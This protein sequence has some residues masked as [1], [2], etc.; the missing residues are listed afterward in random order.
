[1]YR[2][3][4]SVSLIVLIFLGLGEIYGQTLPAKRNPT[5]NAVVGGGGGDTP[6]PLPACH[7]MQAPVITGTST[8]TNG[9]TGSVNV[10]WTNVGASDYTVF[11]RPSGTTTYFSGCGGNPS[12]TISSVPSGVAY[13][14][15]V[16][17]SRDCQTP[18]NGPSVDT[19]TSAVSVANIIVAQPTILAPT[20]VTQSSFTANWSASNGATNYLIDVNTNISFTGTAIL[21]NVS[22]STSTSRTI[23]NLAANTTYYYRVRASNSFATSGSAQSSVP[24]LAIPIPLAPAGLAKT[25]VASTS[26]GLSWATT[27]WADFYRLDLAGTSDFSTDIINSNYQ[28]NSTS[29]TLNGLD[30]NKTYYTRVRAV[31]VSGVSANSQ[32]LSFVTCAPVPINLTSSSVTT[33]SFNLNWTASAGASSYA[34]DVAST[35]NFST[36]VVLSNSPVS[37]PAISVTG[38]APGT[39]YYARVRSVSA[40]GA[41]PN[42][43]NLIVT[44]LPPIPTGG[45]SLSPTTSSFIATW[46]PVNNADHYFVDV[47]TSSSFPTPLVKTNLDAGSTP[48]LNIT[49]LINATTYYFRVRASN[50][51]GTSA[52]SQPFS[53]TTVVMPAPATPTVVAGSLGADIFSLNWPSVT[54]AGNYSVDVSTSSAFDSGVTNMMSTTTTALLTGLQQG[55]TYYCRVRAIGAGGPSAPSPSLTVTTLLNSP[56]GLTATAITSTSFKATWSPIAGA[57]GYRIDVS[58]NNLFSS[59]NVVTDQATASAEYNVS[60]LAPGTTYYYRVKTVRGS[61]VSPYST[62]A[63]MLSAPPAATGLT[64]SSPTV[65]SFTARWQPVTGTVN[66]YLVDIADNAGFNPI[67]LLGVD[68]GTNT[69]KDITGLTNG[70]TYYFRV[71]ATNNGG[72]SVSASALVT[73]PAMGVPADLVTSSITS[74]SFRLFWSP[75]GATSYEANVSAESTFANPIVS[76]SAVDSIT[77]A[78]LSAARSYYCRVRANGS[79]GPSAWSESITIV[80]APVVT[81]A[82]VA[83]YTFVV[84]CTDAGAETGYYFEVSESPSFSPLL[85]PFTGTQPISSPTLNTFGLQPQHTYYVRARIAI[86]HVIS[87]Y[88]ETLSVTSD[89]DRDPEL[90]LNGGETQPFTFN[91]IPPSPEASALAKYADVPVSLYSGTPSISIPLYEVNERGLRLPIS[92]SYHGGGNKV[93]QAAPRTGL[94]WTL[95][96]GGVVTRVVRGW[97]D[98]HPRGFLS[99]TEQYNNVDELIGVSDND[100]TKSDIYHGMASDCKDGEPDL[101]YFNFGG[102]SGQFMYDWDGT[103]RIVSGNSIKIEALDRAD[104]DYFTGWKIT[105]DD[106]TSYVFSVAEISELQSAAFATSGCS[107]LHE[108]NDKHLPQSWYL[109]EMSSADGLCSIRFEY[110]SRDQ[111][112]ESDGQQTLVYD[113]LRFQGHPINAEHFT[114]K[115]TYHGKYL[116]RISTT[117]LQ[118]AVDFE[119]ATQPRTD[120]FGN[121]AQSVPSFPLGRIKVTSATGRS[122]VSWDLNYSN[123]THRLTLESV[124]ETTGAVA[125]PPYKFSYNSPTLPGTNSTSI[126]HWG[127]LNSNTEG[128]IPATAVHIPSMPNSQRFSL[129]GGDRSPDGSKVH[130][131]MLTEI[132]YP[133]GG[134]D[135]LTFESN[136]YSFE[137]GNELTVTD[138]VT[139]EVATTAPTE[140]GERQTSQ[141]FV[142]NDTRNLLLSY[143]FEFGDHRGF[144]GG[145]RNPGVLVVDLGTGREIFH[146]VFSIGE[147]PVNGESTVSG[148]GEEILYQIPPGNYKITATGYKIRFTDDQGTHDTQNSASVSISWKTPVGQP[149]TEIHSGGGVRIKQIVRSFGNGNPDKVTRYDY[150]MIE[151]GML[152]S[153]GSLLEL[154]QMYSLRMR[155]AVPPEAPIVDSLYHLE[156]RYLRFSRNHAPLGTTQGS[157]VGYEQVTVLDGMNGENGKSI[158]HFRSPRDVS[159]AISTDIPFPPARSLDFERGLLLDEA[160]FDAD[161]DTV[162]FVENEYQFTIGN[163]PA[164]KV[165][166][167]YPGESVPWGIGPL[168]ARYAVARYV[169]ALGYSRLTQTREK[170]F[171]PN[172]SSFETVTSYVYNET[173]HKQLVRSSRTNSKGETI[174]TSLKYPQDYGASSAPINKLQRAHI[175]NVPVETLTWKN[176]TG[177]DVQLLSASKTDF[178]IDRLNLIALPQTRSGAKITDPVVTSDPYTTA[179]T[180]Y[181]PRLVVGSY[182]DFNNPRESSR[183]DGKKTAYQ[184]GYNQTVL[185]AAAENALFTDMFYEGFEENPSASVAEQRTGKKSMQLSGVFSIMTDRLPAHNGDY[186]LSYWVKENSGP[187]TYKEKQFN[188]Y[189]TGPIATDAVNGFLDEVRL[190]PKG[191][192]MTTYTYEL[193]I[194]I[195]SITDPANVTTYFEY[196]DFNRLAVK[197]D[198][199]RNI[200]AKYDYGVNVDVPFQIPPPRLTSFAPASGQAG[201]TVV[202]SGFNFSPVPSENTVTFNGVA[203]TV[204]SST[205]AQLSVT[206]PAAATTGKVAITINGATI[207]SDGVFTVLTH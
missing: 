17:A 71:R 190:Y 106:G 177:S 45:S 140:S 69:Q 40:A 28:V 95:N 58:T 12:C 199:D 176:G 65:S 191:A 54:G 101:F 87:G 22:N 128:L 47:S 125:K 103:I 201:A 79:G 30:P 139:H 202:I 113:L 196:D 205:G 153:S 138:S 160:Q 129:P 146:R 133:T 195:T 120:V 151:G 32:T 134:K 186:V 154:V 105:V 37:G 180:L 86:N 110:E 39:T 187:W 33:T 82:S 11:Y 52:S 198:Q 46:Q 188:N 124:T 55:T 38:L 92:L 155:Y 34:V 44:L 162:R 204:N 109:S 10:A 25:A 108:F 73:L 49:G 51:A 89:Q 50:T 148:G 13:D 173:T 63:S 166:W 115:I 175:D 150:K 15:Y 36:G 112:S 94:G 142:L 61:I 31:N 99:L 111:F 3:R 43:V 200:I 74:T 78:G 121:E 131:G 161:G 48:Q 164:L 88:S 70:K 171:Y 143:N 16:Q 122:I 102:Y 118:T 119:P 116:R 75:T 152:K 72:I 147:L 192:L 182:D 84:N 165:G 19:R 2:A 178:V 189:T 132:T 185:V 98:E 24:T 76:T 18:G 7:S 91:I 184:W 107:F 96:A 93:E 183:P 130:A 159:D 163:I 207:K 193:K 136:D 194:G 20:S 168:M 179:S 114:T 29:I 85:D 169:N 67:L 156:P 145:A 144:G 42:S 126:D 41:S 81:M 83:A 97:P 57:T 5:S 59:G 27:V 64:S 23:S 206:V 100:E 80:T 197:R 123:A 157:H 6:P 117:S 203:A 62:T 77:F 170:M 4:I 181:E 9:A 158:Y 21:N 141:T 90:V 127:F 172:A 26:V 174:V 14:V 60:P 135:V 68:A 53:V 8:T 167:R 56:A 104:G 66:R 149:R 137:Q 1:M 35:A